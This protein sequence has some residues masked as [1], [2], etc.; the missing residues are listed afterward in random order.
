[1][2]SNFK[3]V[4]EES[5]TEN[6]E[7]IKLP[8][9][10]TFGK[11]KRARIPNKRYSD[12]LL[13]PRTNHSD[14]EIKPKKP[15]V[16][17]GVIPEDTEKPDK[18]NTETSDSKSDLSID[19][20]SLSSLKRSNTS[21]SSGSPASKKSKVNVDLTNPNYLKPFKYGWKRELVYRATSDNSTKRNGD[22]YYYTPSGKKVRSMREVSEH[23][24]NKELTLDD[25]TF[26]KEPLGLDDPEK[27]IIRDAKYK[28]AG[29]GGPVSRKSLSKAK[30]TK[31]SSPKTS[32]TTSTDT[33]PTNTSTESTKPKA[34]PRISNLKASTKLCFNFC[35]ML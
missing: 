19:S 16:E 5:A 11:G 1:M 7:E 35:I 14:N 28:S 15:A 29:F 27:E 30:T 10:Q 23:L 18:E 2:D 13:S 9:K 8:P 21:I 32:E 6:K 22:I 25:F 12:I 34:S 26:F 17:N 24:K 4:A 31:I 3:I 20:P 33:S